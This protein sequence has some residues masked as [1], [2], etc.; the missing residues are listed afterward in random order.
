M[1]PLVN[2]GRCLLGER[3]RERGMTQV[4]LALKLNMS[5]SRISDYI[6]NR[7]RM[8][9]TTAINIAYAIGCSPF[10]LYEVTPIK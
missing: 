9:L 5:E 3:L 6:H 1:L 7:K 8:S 2:V 4:D 10:D